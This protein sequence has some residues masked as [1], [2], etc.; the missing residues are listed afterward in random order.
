MS[1][2]QVPGL[3]VPGHPD[4]DRQL[5]QPRDRGGRLEAAASLLPA[6]RRAHHAGRMH[7]YS[8]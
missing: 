3:R 6:R 8:Y 4:C 7:F 5:R 2:L 1:L